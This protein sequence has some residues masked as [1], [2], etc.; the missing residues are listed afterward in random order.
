M[1]TRAHGSAG[2]TYHVCPDGLSLASIVYSFGIG[3]D[4]SFESSL[5]EA[6]GLTVFAFD[7]TDESRYYLDENPPPKG[8]VY[9]QCGLAAEDGRLQL[10]TVKRGGPRYRAGT[11]L[12]IVTPAEAP[13]EIEVR[14]LR[15][16]M[17]ERHHTNLDILKLD[18]EGAEF[19]VLE[20]LFDDGIPA[21]QLVL[22]FH[23]HLVNLSRSPLLF[24]GPV[25]ARTEHM[26][27]R[28]RQDG[29]ELIHVSERG[30]E[31]SFRRPTPG[32]SDGSAA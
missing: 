20:S 16:L 23:P 8:F 31:F 32:D 28:I 11:I 25:W 6:Y 9:S 17:R 5:I 29:F 2:G 14:A 27:E 4:T 3:C 26:I 19:P 21:Q 13:V 10:N 22:E 24:W 12:D 7:P 30:T 18:I 15:S 1:R